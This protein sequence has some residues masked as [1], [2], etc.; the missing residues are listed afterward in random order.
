MKETFGEFIKRLR[1]DNNMTLT[2]LAAKLDM[3]SANLCKIENG[4]RDFDEKRLKKLAN[5]FNLDVNQLTSEFFSDFIAKKIYHINNPHETLI[6]ADKKV[7]YL[8]QKN[9]IQ[10]KLNI[11]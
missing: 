5:T 8:K 6:L 1:I 4:R 2:Q 3:D 9:V 10:T 11:Q 7:E